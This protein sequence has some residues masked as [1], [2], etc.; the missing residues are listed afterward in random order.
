MSVLLDHNYCDMVP[1]EDIKN[2]DSSLS[3]DAASAKMDTDLE[4]QKLPIKDDI[5]AVSTNIDAVLTSLSPAHSTDSGV[6]S[7]MDFW[8]NLSSSNPWKH[9]LDFG[10]CD[11]DI[12]LQDLEALLSENFTTN[13]IPSGK[14]TQIDNYQTVSVS[15]PTTKVKVPLC[16]GKEV[17]DEEDPA[18][19]ERNKKN[20]IAARENRQKKKK[21]VEGLENEVGK[22]KE[23]NTSLKARNESMSK[24]IL[25]L[26]DEVK[27][28]RSVLANES[29]ITLLLKSVAATPGIS[30]T[31]SL[32]QSST[33]KNE[34]TPVEIEKRQYITRSRKR[35][36][37]I[38]QSADVKDSTP[39]KKA[40]GTNPGGVCLHVN[41]GKVSLELCAKCEKRAL[42]SGVL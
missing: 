18:I 12:D 9:E 21:Y 16:K 38:V 13:E 26:T 39:Y 3:E 30:L 7:G 35:H 37:D 14:E 29:T 42:Q 15:N 34:G 23:A 5:C 27:Y 36:S 24:M 20:A 32:L 4:E 1:Y 25:K 40:R 28:L 11:D 6:D 8:G 33:N 22:L 10:L 2:D 19:L 41:N 31:S 17:S